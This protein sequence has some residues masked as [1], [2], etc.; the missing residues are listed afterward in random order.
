M[1]SSVWPAPGPRGGGGGESWALCGGGYGAPCARPVPCHKGGALAGDLLE[2]PY[3]EGAPP[4]PPPKTKVTVAG[5][6]ELYH[7]KS[8][9]FWY[10]NL[11]GNAP[12]RDEG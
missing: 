6:N 5:E 10:T 7:W 12:F 9:Q 1:D 8:A 11:W 2:R 3:A 4:P